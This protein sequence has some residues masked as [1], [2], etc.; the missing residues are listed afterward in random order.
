MADRIQKGWTTGFFS[1][2]DA[3]YDAD[4]TGYAKAVYVYLCRRADGDGQCFPGYGTMA[5][6]VGFSKSTVRRAVDE[7]IAAGLLVKE[8][9]GRKE[10]GEYFSNLY[11][12]VHPADADPRK[13]CSDRPYPPE[14]MLSESIPMSQENTPMLPQ[15]IPMLSQSTEGTHTNDTPIRKPMKEID[16]PRVCEEASIEELVQEYTERIGE[17]VN[18]K[19]IANLVKRYGAEKVREKIDVIAGLTSLRSPIAALKAALRED[20]IPDTFPMTPPTPPSARVRDERYAAFY[21]LFPEC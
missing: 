9:R 16:T 13:V 17:N 3:I 5:K 18:P 6:E 20:W 12:I 21:E 10:S 1:A 4:V 7:L 2:P 15:N 14:G 8:V 19:T 11:T